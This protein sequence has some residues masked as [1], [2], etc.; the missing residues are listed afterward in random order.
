MT[1]IILLKESK[2]LMKYNCSSFLL[3]GM[4]LFLLFAVLC[5][6]N[7][8]SKPE[9]DVEGA[10]FQYNYHYSQYEITELIRT[11]RNCMMI[12]SLYYSELCFLIGD[13]EEVSLA[14]DE[15][16]EANFQGINSKLDSICAVFV[17]QQRR[18][19]KRSDI[20]ISESLE[21]EIIECAETG[22]IR[23]FLLDKTRNLADALAHVGCG[24][25]V[26]IRN[27]RAPRISDY[28]RQYH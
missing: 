9:C 4:L 8:D 3:P 14:F 26:N 6:C 20:F 24:A 23:L 19:L 5:S 27:Y 28:L 11:A 2:A 15:S 10:M 13:L 1:W 12:D 22:M 17:Y 7:V 16:E 25:G 21:A 18:H